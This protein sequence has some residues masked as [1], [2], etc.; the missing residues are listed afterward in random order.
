M[1]KVMI[2]SLILAMIFAVDCSKSS[3]KPGKTDFD[4]K[5]YA[6]GY[7]LANRTGLTEIAK[8]IDVDVLLQG[9]RD[10]LT[11]KTAKISAAERDEILKKFQDEITEKQLEQIRLKGEKNKVEGR[12]FLEKNA[13]KAGVKTTASGLQYEVLKTGTGV[14]AKVT[15]KVKVHYRGALIDGTEFDSSYKRGEPTTFPLKS[16]IP[17]W[18][19]GVQ[20]MNVGSQYRLIIPP[21]LAYGE[22]GAGSLIAPYAVLIFEIEL[23]GIEPGVEPVKK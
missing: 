15:D 23:L 12:A 4:K 22:R 9:L 16:V 18:I 13:K 10:A 7:D 20:L 8:E 17:G 14:N 5:S 3:E 6:V 11:E 1:K 2:L 19:E 21:Q